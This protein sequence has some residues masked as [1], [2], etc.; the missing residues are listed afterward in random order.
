MNNKEIIEKLTKD[1]DAVVREIEVL[2]INKEAIDRTIAFYNSM[3]EP[4][5]PA[6]YVPPVEDNYPAS[7]TWREKIMYVLSL[8]S[9]AMKSTDLYKALH[10]K[11]PEV[12]KIKADKNISQTLWFLK[13]KKI[14]SYSDKTYRVVKEQ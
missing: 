14:L 7:G 9:G 3:G 4:F 12:D 5:L 10:D 1:R 13:D 11:E 8:N 2:Q 6:D